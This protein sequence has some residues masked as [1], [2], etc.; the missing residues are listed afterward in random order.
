MFRH[1]WLQEGLEERFRQIQ[2]IMFKD[3]GYYQVGY[4]GKV[5]RDSLNE[6]AVTHRRD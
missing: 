4:M 3:T 1:V 2:L 5:T 6:A